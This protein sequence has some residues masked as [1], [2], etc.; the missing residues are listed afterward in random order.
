MPRSAECLR[1]FVLSIEYWLSPNGR[2]RW[3]LKSNVLPVPLGSFIPAVVLMPVISLVLH[4]VD[5]WLSMLMSIVL[6]LMALS[7]SRHDGRAGHKT[8]SIF[9][10]GFIPKTKMKTVVPQVA[11]DLNQGRPQGGCQKTN[12]VAV[13]AE[14]CAPSSWLPF[15]QKGTTENESRKWRGINGAN[16]SEIKGGR[17]VHQSP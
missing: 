14:L 8:F 11:D 12:L 2:L 1:H 16:R 4:E 5:G 17:P 6:K 3:W 9:V 13:G 7:I 15:N 10:Q